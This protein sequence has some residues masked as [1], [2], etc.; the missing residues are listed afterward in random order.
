MRMKCP[1]CRRE[2]GQP[3]KYQVIDCQ[4]GRRLMVIEIDK[5]KSIEDVTP[6]KED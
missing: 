4:C 2:I 1:N 5:V 6:D 3:K